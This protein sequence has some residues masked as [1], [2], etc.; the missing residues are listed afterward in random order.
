MTHTDPNNP[1]NHDAEALA[2]WKEARSHALAMPL[3]ILTAA[4][5]KPLRDEVEAM[6]RRD[7]QDRWSS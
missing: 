1:A 4:D 3:R 2:L 7:D 6:Q 5:R